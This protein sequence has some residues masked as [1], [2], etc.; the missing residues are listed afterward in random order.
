MENFSYLMSKIILIII[1]LYF[2]NSFAMLFGGGMPLDF[3]KKWLDNQ[4]ILGKGKTIRG[5]IA[6]VFFGSFASFIVVLINPAVEQVYQN[7][8]LFGFLLS[9]GAIIGD[10][11]ASFFKRRNKIDPGNPVLFLDQ[12]DFVFGGLVFGSIMYAPTF[13][14]ILAIVIITLIAHKLSNYLAYKLKIKKVPW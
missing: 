8:V 12:L 10:I 5:T 11:V 13:Y 6:G 9:L 7:Y 14:E 1:P 4:P 3:G 2:A